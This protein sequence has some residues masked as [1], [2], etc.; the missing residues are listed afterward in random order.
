M[1]NQKIIFIQNFLSFQLFIRFILS[2][3]IDLSLRLSPSPSLLSPYLNLS[4]ILFLSITSHRSLPQIFTHSCLAKCRSCH[5]LCF[6]SSPRWLCSHGFS[7]FSFLSNGGDRWV[8]IGFWAMYI[9]FIGGDDG[10]CGSLIWWVGFCGS[11][12]FLVGWH[13]FWWF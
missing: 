4:L 7:L 11:L 9:G 13:L 2:P 8:S 3:L 6:H 10:L 5:G 1:L 12:D